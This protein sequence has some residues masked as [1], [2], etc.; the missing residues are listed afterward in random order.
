VKTFK[1]RP[2]DGGSY[3]QNPDGTWVQVEAPTAPCPRKSDV[4]AAAEPVTD[5][6]RQARARK[7]TEE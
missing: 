2:A 3:Q 1:E 5:A 4:A 7:P 6:P